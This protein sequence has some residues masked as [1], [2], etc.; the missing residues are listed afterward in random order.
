MQKIKTDRVAPAILVLL[1]ITTQ[2]LAQ[3][4]IKA[5]WYPFTFPGNIDSIW[6]FEAKSVK[7]TGDS[8][9]LWIDMESSEMT[10]SDKYERSSSR[11]YIEFSCRNSTYRTLSFLTL[12]DRDNVTSQ[13]GPDLNYLPIPPS[14]MLDAAKEQSCSKGFP[15]KITSL[16]KGF[17]NPRIYADQFFNSNDYKA[18]ISNRNNKNSVDS[19]N[20]NGTTPD[21]R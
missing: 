18:V 8:V 3:P 6:A 21:S 16:G 9:K 5:N 7:H 20:L 19:S 15:A 13:N 2:A 17:L 14:T 11:F 4:T 1:W 10:T 12:D